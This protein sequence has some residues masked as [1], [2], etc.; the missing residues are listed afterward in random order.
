MK[1]E[2]DLTN[3]KS[4]QIQSLDQL[5]ENFRALWREK[6]VS[7]EDFLSEHTVPADQQNQ[8]K[9]RLIKSEIE[10]KRAAG[11][12]CSASDYR[13]RFP[14][15]DSEVME[16]LFSLPAPP[17]VSV[18]KPLLPSRYVPIKEIGKGGIG[19]VWQVDD[20]QMDRT[21]AVKV[22][23][24]RFEKDRTANL[25]MKQE[26]R[27]TGLLQHPGIP[28]VFEHGTLVSGSQYF[29]M[30]L[31]EGETLD[32][33]FSNRTQ[34]EL[35]SIF[36]QIAEAVGFAH[37]KNII[38]RDLKP[39]NVMVGAF[40][41]VQ[42][43]DWGMAR[44]LDDGE[45]PS[46]ILRVSPDVANKIDTVSA[47]CDESV[48]ENM[49]FTSLLEHTREGEIMGTPA[50]MAPEQARGEIGSINASSDVFGLGA[51]LFALL[52]GKRLY[53]GLDA[54][55]MI[56]KAAKGDLTEAFET[57]EQ[58]D[59]DD[60]L[61]Q[62]CRDCIQ[63]KNEDRP[64]DAS[65]IAERIADYQNNVQ[66]RLRQAEL[67]QRALA[68]EADEQRKRRRAVTWLSSLV[69]LAT[70]AGLIGVIWQWN[71]AASSEK[72][73]VNR[74]K[75]TRKTVDDFYTTI[76]EDRGLLAG[77]PG[78]QKLRRELLTKAKN[79][80]V[81]FIDENAEDESTWLEMAK[82][83]DRL[84][85]IT[86]DLDPGCDEIFV[87]LGQQKELLQK[88]IVKNKANES[89][90]EYRKLLF[91]AQTQ[92]TVELAAK[93]E[94]EHSL[95]EL[96][97]C[98][99]FGQ[100]WIEID[101]SVET[102]IHWAKNYHYI[103]KR[104]EQLKRHK[105][106]IKDYAEALR[107]QE[108]IWKANPDNRRCGH[109]LAMTYNS[110][111]VHYGFYAKETRDWQKS[112]DHFE[113]SVKLLEGLFESN[114]DDLKIQ[115]LLPSVLNNLGMAHWNNKK[116]NV[117]NEVEKRRQLADAAFERGIAIA[118]RLNREHPD[119]PNFAF[120]LAKQ[121]GNLA[122][123]KQ[124]VGDPQAQLECT[125]RA[126][127][128]ACDVSDRHPQVEDYAVKA[129][130]LLTE[131]ASLLELCDESEELIQESYK[132]HAR[133]ASQTGKEKHRVFWALSQGTVKKTIS[134]ML[135]DL[136]DSFETADTK[137]ANLVVA[138]A[139]A[140]YRNEKLD[141]ASAVLEKFK[142]P[143]EPLYKFAK[144][145]LLA[146]SGKNEQA[147]TLLTEGRGMIKKETYTHLY[148]SRLSLAN[149]L[150]EFLTAE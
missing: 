75:E 22:L 66:H 88:L 29:A 17:P 97:I 39:Q 3:A 94:Y 46:A 56:S 115:E 99:Q 5:A 24:H 140:L 47:K 21:L 118:E 91:V 146:R 144:G 2:P 108:P 60:E 27:L 41:E 65:V 32:K 139:M 83:Y 68:V 132:Y 19:S 136:T 138:R 93:G 134:P 103:G 33:S 42:I 20:K 137:D 142:R 105:E 62:L 143:K 55:A 113:E 80:Y 124:Y 38:H 69:L 52:T 100:D 92:V 120:R 35:L 25:R 86:S 67:D 149:E 76:A 128:V 129:R 145:I 141:E 43:M 11:A 61:K 18:L 54:K 81:N 148:Y 14:E 77:S 12:Q 90:P 15:V 28:P 87:L 58:S 45:E 73:A 112:V 59:F 78:T 126:A 57:L 127:K 121:L 79:Y 131:I 98:S 13:Q 37:S 8:L 48:D 150:E 95:E 70:I 50:Y 31:V 106:A 109:D 130:V 34:A 117:E 53:Q 125:R 7:V 102:Q 63:P 6:P 36:R 16:N 133:L 10:L 82:A 44:R 26:A 84:I 4:I 147:K 74:L 23:H 110:I 123:F 111:G 72:L 122:Q 119:I 71:N 116:E 1:T 107:L 89:N 104:K 96:K 64:R 101:D 30:K 9:I 49:A 85:K 135:L 51:I 114:P 40:G